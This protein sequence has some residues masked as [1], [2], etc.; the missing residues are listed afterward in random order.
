MFFLYLESR[1]LTAAPDIDLP[2]MHLPRQGGSAH[3]PEI[4]TALVRLFNDNIMITL[5]TDLVQ[6][7]YTY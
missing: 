6:Q 1:A 7:F 2:Y 3:S 5:A 4:G